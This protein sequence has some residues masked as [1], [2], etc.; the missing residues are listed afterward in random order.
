MTPSFSLQPHL[1]QLHAKSAHTLAFRAQTLEEF[2]E[3]QHALRAKLKQL[4]GIERRHHQIF[5]SL[6][7]PP[8]HRSTLSMNTPKR[9]G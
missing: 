2:A 1:D 9:F 4:L 3:W 7:T 5:V 6:L 8:R